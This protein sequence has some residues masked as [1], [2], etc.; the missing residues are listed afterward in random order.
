M[1]KVKTI[2]L[3]GLPS[4]QKSRLYGQLKEKSNY[5]RQSVNLIDTSLTY[6]EIINALQQHL[7]QKIQVRDLDLL[8][9]LV[10]MDIHFKKYPLWLANY[11]KTDGSD[12]YLV[13]E[14][15]FSLSVT[16][17]NTSSSSVLFQQK[18]Y[19]YLDTFNLNYS[20]ISGKGDAL[21]INA[22]LECDF[23][24]GQHNEF[25][26]FMEPS[27]PLSQWHPSE[28]EVD[29]LSFCCGEQFMMYQK[30]ILF[31]DFEMADKI[32]ATSQPNEHQAFGR[33]VKGFNSKIWKQHC[34][35]IV[36]KGNYAKFTQNEW[37][38]D[39][40]HN[41]KD[42]LLVEAYDQ[43]TYWSVGLVEENPTIKNPQLW[44]GKNWIGFILTRVREEV[45][46]SLKIE[47]KVNQ[48][49]LCEAKN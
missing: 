37:L 9:T 1:K 40:L 47:S 46:Q 38:W 45:R 6:D 20:T 3:T 33:A 13:V 35:D 39:I 5:F 27:S 12:F 18:L 29:G 36:Y 15:D 42:S 26:F 49:S 34:R 16:N 2:A 48:N 22:M 31:K 4:E 28:F 10:W 43:C 25:T 17:E 11:I 21:L 32:M 30:A 14:P 19:H 24:L 8:N 23:Y 41:T 44:P 7:E